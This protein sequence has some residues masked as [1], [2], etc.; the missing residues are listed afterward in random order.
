[1][2][3][4][5]MFSILLLLVLTQAGFSQVAINTTGTSA[6]PSAMLDINAANKGLLIPRV[7]LSGIANNIEP[8]SN[9]ATGLLVYNMEGN[10]LTPGIY[11][12]TGM[13][14]S[15]MATLEQVHNAMPDPSGSGIFGEMHE[16]NAIGSWSNIS[17]PSSG[18]FVMWST[19][20]QG[21]I[22]GMSCSSSSFIIENS[23][24][25]SV[26]FSSV[27][28][29]PAGGKIVDAA[30]FVNGSR[31][32]DLHGRTWFKEGGKAQGISFSGLKALEADNVVDVRYT[33]NDDEVIRIEIANLSLT[34]I[35]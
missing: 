34:K 32:D 14:W 13:N 4:S 12:W 18:S 8:V 11:M 19:A 30:L 27:V 16:Y 23:G 1:M 22:S 21:D 7:S 5:L 35:D 25:Y 2:K 3:N 20:S 28:Q 24:M 29:L 31:Q 17:I 26:S 10:D 33:M 9:P 6:D 15:S